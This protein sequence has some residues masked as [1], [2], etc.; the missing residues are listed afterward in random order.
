MKN[1]ITTCEKLIKE[2]KNNLNLIGNRIDEHLSKF[3]DLD[4]LLENAKLV[5]QKYF[6]EQDEYLNIDEFK[7]FIKNGISI[8]LE[9]LNYKGDRNGLKKLLEKL[10]DFHEKYSEVIYFGEFNPVKAKIERLENQTKEE[11]E[12]DK[13]R[14]FFGG[15]IGKIINN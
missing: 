4:L 6:E 12:L 10:G 11:I 15:L 13:K 8:Y 7:I 1:G 2:D 3:K 14:G 5:V 9:Y